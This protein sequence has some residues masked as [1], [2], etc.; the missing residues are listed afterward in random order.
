MPIHQCHSNEAEEGYNQA[1]AKNHMGHGNS[2]HFCIENFCAPAR[3]FTDNTLR[4]CVN[5]SVQNEPELQ[6]NESLFQS[7]LDMLLQL[8]TFSLS[9]TAILF[10]WYRMPYWAQEK[11]SIKNVLGWKEICVSI[12]NKRHLKVETLS[13]ENTTDQQ[14]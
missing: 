7:H 2:S 13:D 1:D 14:I 6:M 9:D 12:C 10:G 4:G 8:T 5:I 11:I 3:C